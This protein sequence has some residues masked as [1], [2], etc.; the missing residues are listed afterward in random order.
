MKRFVAASLLA[1]AGLSLSA[2]VA[3]A[4]APDFQTL[5]FPTVV[6]EK[7]INPTADSTISY[8]EVQVTIPAGTFANP[9]K[10]QVIEGPLA[11]FQANAPA[12]ETVLMDF[13]FKV[14]DTTTNQLV[15]KFNK[16]VVVAYTDARVNANSKYYNTTTDGKF[17][18]NPAAPIITGNTLKHGNPGAGVGWAITSP[19]TAVKNA[20]S[21]VTGLPF[22]TAAEAGAVLLLGGGALMFASRKKAN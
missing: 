8:G 14:T 6:A 20:T 13:A 19:A 22:A 5:G 16:P 10:F 18:L 21:P 11:S 2:T 15:G 9:V 3:F 12:G 4:A 1:T 17:V 7:A